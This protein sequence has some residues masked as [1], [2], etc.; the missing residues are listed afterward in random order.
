MDS[1]RCAPATCPR[2]TSNANAKVPSGEHHAICPE[3]PPK[4]ESS[5]AAQAHSWRSCGVS[6][7]DRPTTCHGISSTNSGQSSCCLNR[8][9]HRNSPNRFQSLRNRWRKIPKAKPSFTGGDFVAAQRTLWAARPLL[10]KS[11]TVTLCPNQI[12]CT[13]RVVTR[14]HN[15]R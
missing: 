9:C 15:K 11:R 8:N 10:T 4:T 2:S 14:Q 6:F 13:G 1:V 3:T 7:I 5:T 12:P